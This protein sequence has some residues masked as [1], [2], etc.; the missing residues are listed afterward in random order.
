MYQR[1]PVAEMTAESPIKLAHIVLRSTNVPAMRRWY[2][3]V[4]NAREIVSSGE[5]DACGLTYDDEHHRVLIIGM[6]PEDVERQQS[7]GAL[8]EQINER[9]KAPGLEHVAFTFNGIGVLLGNYR[10]L[11]AA[12]IEPVLCVNHGPVMSMYYLDPD[13]NNVELQTDTMPMDM[14]A[15]FMYSEEFLN[16]SIGAPYDLEILC[17]MYDEG[18]PLKEIASYGFQ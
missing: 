15:E 8:F 12:G 2:M 1:T 18:V 3:T 4:L 5:G 14:A 6:P 17:S 9:R 7:L 16:N 13:G 10:R 11:K